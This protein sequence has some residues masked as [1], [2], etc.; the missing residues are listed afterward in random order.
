V[1]AQLPASQ[2][3]FLAEMEKG[4]TEIDALVAQMNRLLL[5]LEGRALGRDRNSFTAKYYLPFFRELKQKDYVELYVYWASQRA[6]IPGVREWL[7]ANQTR[8]R[9]FVAWINQYAWPAA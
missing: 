4:A 9:E 8:V 7:M 3:A 6:P 2:R 5:F 1:E